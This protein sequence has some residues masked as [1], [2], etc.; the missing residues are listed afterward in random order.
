MLNGQDCRQISSPV[1]QSSSDGFIGVF[2][3]T[4]QGELFLIHFKVFTFL[5]PSVTDMEGSLD[6]CSVYSQPLFS[7]I[8]GGP[9]YP[10]V[11]CL[12]HAVSLLSILLSFMC[13]P[14]ISLHGL[15]FYS[16]E[17]IFCPSGTLRFLGV[18]L[19]VFVF[20]FNF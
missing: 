12:I 2:S 16:L 10:F 18:F 6:R 4:S 5:T 8:H 15:Y 20:V 11:I 14:I 13:L 1:F 3:C 17:A 19:C 7:F 9:V